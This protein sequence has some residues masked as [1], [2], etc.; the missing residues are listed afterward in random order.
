MK[1]KKLVLLVTMI[2]MLFAFNAVASAEEQSVKTHGEALFDL[3][4]IQGSDK[5]LNESGYLN[6]AEMITILNRLD[7]RDNSSFVA[8][9]KATFSDVPKTH[10][11]YKEVELAYHNGITT[12]L[13]N[14]KFG[15]SDKVTYQQAVTFLARITDNEINYANAIDEGAYL[16]I[17][18]WGMKGA[19]EHLYRADVFEL[20]AGTLLVYVGGSEQMLI[21]KL[22][23]D[24]AKAEAFVDAYFSAYNPMEKAFTYLWPEAYKGTDETFKKASAKEQA[25]AAEFSE[26]VDLYKGYSEYVSLETFLQSAK[27]NEIAFNFEWAYYENSA[28]WGEYGVWGSS[29]G[30]LN[31][32]GILEADVEATEGSSYYTAFDPTVEDFGTATV[33]GRTVQL[34]YIEMMMENEDPDAMVYDVLHLFFL[35]D[36]NGV[37]KMLSSGAFGDGIYTRK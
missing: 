27:K 30:T 6:R 22:N 25:I 34:Y 26:I 10:W 20:M 36:S 14:G 11:A 7:S 35:V 2:S 31:A 1:M 18:L 37:Y 13:G 32:E 29:N 15:V 5:G 9:D 12:G 16:G 23:I 28:I 17:Q 3:G 8:P 24:E 21:E 33:D 19:S 4:L